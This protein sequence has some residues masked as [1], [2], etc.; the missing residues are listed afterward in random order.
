MD[1][2]C[3]YVCN[4]N[5]HLFFL[6]SVCL[7]DMIL[8]TLLGY[9]NR[10]I[11]TSEAWIIEWSCTKGKG[12][13]FWTHLIPCHE[14]KHFPQTRVC[15]WTCHW[16]SLWRKGC[17]YIFW[18]LQCIFCSLYIPPCCP[19]KVILVFGLYISVHLRPD[20]KN[21]VLWVMKLFFIYLTSCLVMKLF[22][23][24]FQL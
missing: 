15:W 21:F 22:Y 18:R 2:T 12:N 8:V 6:F 7:S 20:K 19:F 11:K 14:G 24:L 4:C 13:G 9:V 3:I 16:P 17:C 1:H 5:P 10:C 23:Y